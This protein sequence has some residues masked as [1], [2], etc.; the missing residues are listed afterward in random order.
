MTTPDILMNGKVCMVTGATSGMG[1]MTARRLAELGATVI[2][3]GR[4]R[5]RGDE[6]LRRIVAAT[7]NTSV[8]LM[9]ADLSSQAQIRQLAQRFKSRYQQLH[10]LV[11]NAGAWITTRQECIDGIEMTFALN[12]LGYFLLTNLLLDTLKASAP[13]R[14]INVAS[15]G[16]ASGR[17]DFDDLQG[18]R[19]YNGMQAYRQSKLANVLFTYE[20]AR[21]LAGTGVTVNAV[22]PGLVAT[23]FGLNNF[24]V[25]PARI[26][27]LL[28]RVYGL[29]GANA[30][31]GAQTSIYLATSP[32]VE[33]ITGKYF[34]KQT[35]VPSSEE[36]YDPATAS[37]LWQVSE[38]MTGLSA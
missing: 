17:I 28:I 3:V 26:V 5:E 25:I 33:G 30:E 8:E 23:R 27:N 11:N 36:S 21:R 9:L 15:Y 14:I 32:N 12:H 1:E 6:T 34:E 38:A 10:V 20:L 13:A 2:L 7:G 29:V 24:G 35:A 18:R 16:H 4:S 22:N 31:Q 19:E 37:R